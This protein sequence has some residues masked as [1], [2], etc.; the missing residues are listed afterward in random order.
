MAHEFTRYFQ[1]LYHSCLSVSG[2]EQRPDMSSMIS[3]D[4]LCIN[5]TGVSRSYE[6]QDRVAERAGVL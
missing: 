2:G 3:G 5:S 1:T 4:L 6:G